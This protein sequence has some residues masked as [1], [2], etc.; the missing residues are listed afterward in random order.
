MKKLPKA[1]FYPVKNRECGS[2]TVCCTY[3]PISI[4]NKKQLTPCKYLAKPVSNGYTG[5]CKL[6]CSI[7]EER[8]EVCKGYSCMWLYGYGNEEDRPDKCGILID[9]LLPIANCIQCKPI[10]KGAADTPEGRAAINRISK[11]RN[12]P[13]LVA[14]FPETHMVRVVGRGVE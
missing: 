8:P 12:Q 6:N 10:R 1:Q 13:A 14:G 5:P 3:L 2:C 4:L 11:Q 9:N 7:Y